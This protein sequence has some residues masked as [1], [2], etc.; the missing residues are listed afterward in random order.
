LCL[1][2]ALL[3]KDLPLFFNDPQKNEFVVVRI[4]GKACIPMLSLCVLLVDGF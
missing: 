3:T 1:L 2:I 4:K